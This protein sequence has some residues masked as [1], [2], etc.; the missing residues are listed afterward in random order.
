[1][2][3]VNAADMEAALEFLSSTDEEYARKQALYT[4]LDE[5]TKSVKA[6]IAQMSKGTSAA[7]KEM[8][9]LQS[10]AYRQ[11]LNK[12]QNAHTDYL[13][14]K[15]QRSTQSVVID[16]WRSLNSARNKGQVI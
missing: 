8:F 1:M 16:C 15:A 2:A 6:Q 5:Q 9:A 10:D 4:G 3:L 14:L 7:A 13:I 11:H 12:V